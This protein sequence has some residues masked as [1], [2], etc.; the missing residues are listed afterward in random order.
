MSAA[1]ET[2]MREKDLDRYRTEQ[3][4]SAG[5]TDSV[6]TDAAAELLKNDRSNAI[7]PSPASAGRMS[8]NA[9]AASRLLRSRKDRRHKPQSPQ[10]PS[11]ESDDRSIASLDTLPTSPKRNP[12]L[13][14]RTQATPTSPN[15]TNSAPL[16]PISN[17]SNQSGI[18]SSAS[19]RRTIRSRRERVAGGAAA[20]LVGPAS[21]NSLD[22]KSENNNLEETLT[23]EQLRKLAVTS[24]ELDEVREQTRNE[25]LM[26]P[27][28][29]SRYRSDSEMD[30]EG[31]ETR[32]DIM[33]EA[34]VPSILNR[35]EVFH[36]NATAAILALLT[37]RN[38]GFGEGSVASGASG[39][40]PDL[41]VTAVKSGII[42]ESNVPIS[43]SA[44]NSPR[45]Q[46]DTGSVMSG[47]TPVRNNSFRDGMPK[48]PSRTPKPLLSNI[49]ERKLENIQAR[50][51]DPNKQL[52]ELLLAIA[53]PEDGQ[54][55]DR[56]FMVRRKNA[57]GA[58]KVLTSN[59]TNRRRI[60]WTV[61]VLPAL[62]S[63]LEDTGSAFSSIYTKQEYM[64]A[65]TRA[66]AILLHL[67]I[68][69][70]NRL[71]I[72]HSQGLVQALLRVIADDH[73]EARQ[74]CCGILAYLAKT[75]ENRLLMVQIPSLLDAAT[76][77]IKPIVHKPPPPKKKYHWDHDDDD[78]SRSSD[79]DP[80]RNESMISEG[81]D[82]FAEPNSPASSHGDDEDY[83]S[84]L[85]PQ[86]TASPLSIM[87]TK[88]EQYD[89]EPN[90][91]LHASRQNVFATLLHL[92]KEK[93]NAVSSF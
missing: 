10:H 16:S 55:M 44:F 36:E 9:V 91:F 48:S 82:K 60:C 56:G 35:S 72:F 11:G 39:A 3:E 64:E 27:Q 66:V 68:N 62:T 80:E 89:K 84:E 41:Q 31:E 46:N 20:K 42:V 90:L 58:L 59:P 32:T 38:A 52:S 65:R 6:F 75:N 8:R 74:G 78:S 18:A 40:M 33:S 12:K 2:R 17:A 30:E 29:N 53:S 7:P 83:D 69:K 54:P 43:T 86:R 26:G 88:G 51:R 77:V 76:S 47:M 85:S 21:P 87:M 93:D 14:I 37:P 28:E 25:F 4:S 67:S 73:G 22:D 23:A 63:V 50:M 13:K 24:Q 5:G 57:C 49:A 19:M 15:S 1:L 92:I 81:S 45:N 34:S 71:P 79:D 61:G 70:E